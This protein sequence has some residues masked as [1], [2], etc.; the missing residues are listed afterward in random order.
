MCM[1]VYVWSCW[2]LFYV[3]V[4][5]LHANVCICLWLFINKS[6][7]YIFLTLFVSLRQSCSLKEKFTL[8]WLASQNS[9]GPPVFPFHWCW[10]YSLYVLLFD[11]SVLYLRSCPL[12][13]VTHALTPSP[14]LQLH[15]LP[16]YNCPFLDFKFEIHS[17]IFINC[18][19]CEGSFQNLIVEK[20]SLLVSNQLLRSLL[21]T[22]TW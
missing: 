17:T 7:Y 14:C 3:S 1:H 12:S 21:N 22:H 19:L 2:N 9:W 5:M 16:A 15:H 6:E 8:A 20:G 18:L 4:C 11:L 10:D 13:C